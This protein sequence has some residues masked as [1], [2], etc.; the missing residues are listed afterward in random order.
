M[1]KVSNARFDME[2]TPENHLPTYKEISGGEV[3]KNPISGGAGDASLSPPQEHR[4][5]P[6]LSLGAVRVPTFAPKGD[7]VFTPFDFRQ[8]SGES[9]N[10]L[11]NENATTHRHWLVMAP[12][13]GYPRKHHRPGGA[14]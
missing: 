2:I 10:G 7:E 6:S 4:H 1:N 11:E 12:A 14:T 13:R 3:F 8:A 9:G 5:T